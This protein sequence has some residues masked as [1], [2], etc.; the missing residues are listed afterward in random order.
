MYVFRPLRA[1]AGYACPWRDHNDGELDDKS[2][3][4][5][6]VQQLLLI[7]TTRIS[8]TRLSAVAVIAAQCIGVVYRVGRRGQR[9]T[10]SS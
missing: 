10:L 3:V 2:L 6:V 5:I 1:T 9:L 8:M 4:S 7:V